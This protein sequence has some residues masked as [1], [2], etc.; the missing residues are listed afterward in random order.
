MSIYHSSLPTYL[1][2]RNFIV[3]QNGFDRRLSKTNA[4]DFKV[5]TGSDGL[6][7]GTG[8]AFFKQSPFSS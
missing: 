5:L 7:A 2:N 4:S 1:S 8:R 3:Y 6:L